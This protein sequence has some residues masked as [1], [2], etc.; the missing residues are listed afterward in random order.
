MRRKR[1]LQRFSKS[2]QYSWA[3]KTSILETIRRGLVE[4]GRLAAY[5][6]PDDEQ[7]WA[8]QKPRFGSG[9]PSF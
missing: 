5:K 8:G 4:Q 2:M 9:S 1:R 6:L 7:Y 3:G